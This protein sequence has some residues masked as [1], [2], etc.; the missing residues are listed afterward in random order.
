MR[1]NWWR[2]MARQGKNG[3]SDAAACPQSAETMKASAK[4]LPAS[5][6]LLLAT[7]CGYFSSGTWEDDPKNFERAWGAGKPPDLVMLH[8]WYWRSPHFT[9]E[10]SYFFDFA[11]NEKFLKDFVT[12]NNMQR[13]TTSPYPSFCFER[14][15]WFL[16]TKPLES[17]E[18]RALEPGDRA[19]VFRDKA[20][21]EFFIYGCQI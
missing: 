4:L 19:L 10:E 11:R 2:G 7:G 16:P 20:T 18:I 9:R 12:A 14:P 6:I 8:S 21:G 17:Y 13:R 15:S 3:A 1:T 5:I